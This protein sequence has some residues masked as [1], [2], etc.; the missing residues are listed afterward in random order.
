LIPEGRSP[1]RGAHGVAHA[2]A[3]LRP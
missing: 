2:F 3:S 1:N